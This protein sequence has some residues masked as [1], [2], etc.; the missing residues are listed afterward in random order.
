MSSDDA[1]VRGTGRMQID[2]RHNPW[3]VRKTIIVII[4]IFIKSYPHTY[5]HIHTLST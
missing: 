3:E 4:T 1:E 5:P 2:T